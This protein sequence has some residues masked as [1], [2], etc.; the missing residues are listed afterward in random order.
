VNPR[1]IFELEITMNVIVL[2]LHSGQ[3]SGDKFHTQEEKKDGE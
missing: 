2:A 3:E 1:K